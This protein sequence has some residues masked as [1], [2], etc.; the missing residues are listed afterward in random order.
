MN[1]CVGDE[2]SKLGTHLLLEW[3]WGTMSAP[4]LQQAAMYAQ[5]DGLQQKS[6]RTTCR[7]GQQRDLA[8]YHTGT[9]VYII[10]PTTNHARANVHRV[11][12]ETIVRFVF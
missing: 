10:E 2:V 5:E 1:A 6:H 8:T 12:Y 7:V 3:G 4:K 11:V 9:P